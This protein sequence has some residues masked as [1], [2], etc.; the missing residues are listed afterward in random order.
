MHP[1]VCPATAT[2]RQLLGAL[3]WVLKKDVPLAKA[4][5]PCSEKRLYD[6][7]QLQATGV[8]TENWIKSK[9]S[10]HGE[11]LVGGNANKKLLKEIRATNTDETTSA[12]AGPRIVG[13]P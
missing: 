3:L 2:S 10:R 11:K 1:P 9:R 8:S 6:T 4:G 7:A 12:S 5:M 13:S